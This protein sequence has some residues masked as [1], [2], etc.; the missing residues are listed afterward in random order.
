MHLTTFSPEYEWGGLA[1]SLVPSLANVHACFAINPRLVPRHVSVGALQLRQRDSRDRLAY[2]AVPS[3][4]LEVVVGDITAY[5]RRVGEA[6]K[7]FDLAQV[8]TAPGAGLES[9]TT[10]WESLSGIGPWTAHYVAMRVL[11]EPDALPIGDLGLRKAITKAGEKPRPERDVE[12]TLEGCR[13][14]RA[15]AAMRLWG[16]LE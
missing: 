5:F 11:R 12:T 10:R 8:H 15:Y 2:V 13:P 9:G 16:L 3:L 4:D 7:R 6:F 1:S 14:Y